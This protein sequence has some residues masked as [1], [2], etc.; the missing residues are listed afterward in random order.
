M[1][2]KQPILLKLT[3]QEIKT[4]LTQPSFILL[5][6]LAALMG[7]FVIQ[8][9]PITDGVNVWGPYYLAGTVVKL[10]FILP[11]LIAIF[12]TKAAVR[13]VQHNMQELIFSTAVSKFDWLASRWSGLFTATALV[14]LSFVLGMIAGLHLMELPAI[15]Y[16]TMLI[17]FAWPSLLFI[18]PAI[19]LAVSL[20]FAIGLFSRSSLVIF[21]FAGFAFIGYQTLLM[22]TGSPIMAKPMVL[23]DTLN[24]VFR[25]IDPVGSSVFFEQVKSWS[26]NARNSQQVILDTPLLLNRALVLVATALTIFF[27]YQKFSLTLALT[28]LKKTSPAVTNNAQPY[29]AVPINLTWSAKLAGFTSLCRL[30]YLTTIKTKSFALVSIFLTLVVA[31]EVFSGL[32]Y[33]ETMGVTPLPTT[34]VAFN[35]FAHDVLPNFG[36]LFLAF[37]VAQVMWRDSELNVACLIETTNTSNRQLFSAKWLTLLLIPITFISIAIIVASIMQ[38]L[39]G[40]TIEWAIYLSAFYYVGAPLIALA[41]LF[42][43]LHTLI[44]SK[45]VAMGLSFIV[46]VLAQSNFGSYIGIEHKML[47]FA[48]TPHMSH[49]QLI[50]FDATATAFNH[51]I[52]FWLAL[53]VAFALIGFGLFRRGLDVTLRQR[54]ILS[55]HR[56]KGHVFSGA[57]CLLAILG[58]GAHLFY[59]ANIIGQYKNSDAL[60]QWRVDYEKKYIAYQGLPQP[61]IVDVNT[62]LDFFPSERRFTLSAKYQLSNKTAKPISQVLIN[63]HH[64]LNYSSLTLS[65]AT[66]ASHDKALKQY[67]WQLNSPMQPGDTIALDFALD[68]QQTGHNGVIHDNF[69]SDKFSYFRDLRYMPFLGFAKH[70]QIKSAQTRKEHGLEPL[71]AA[72]SLEQDIALHQGDFSADYRWASTDITVSTIKGQTAIAPGELVKQWTVDNR[73]YFQYVNQQPMRRVLAYFSLDLVKSTKQVDGVNLE[74][75]HQSQSQD[76][77]NEHLAAMADTVTYANRHFSP[78]P[79]KQLRLIEVPS[80]LGYSGYALSQTILLDERFGFGVKRDNGKAIGFDHLYRRTV[81]ETAHQWWGYALDSAMTE[82]VSLLIESLAKLTEVLVLEKKF[83]PEYVRTLVRYEHNRYFSGRGNSRQQELP[84]YRSGE[85]HVVYSK[86]SVT[87]NALVTRLGEKALTDA[88]AALIKQHHYPQRPAT[89]LDFIARLKETSEPSQHQFIDHWLKN[90]AFDDWQITSAEVTE[91]KDGGFVA[92]VCY[93]NPSYV[94]NPNGKKSSKALNNPAQLVFLSAH[95]SRV[96]NKG[97]DRR[98]LKVLDIIGQPTQQ[99]AQQQLTQ[100]PSHIAI[101]PYYLTLDNSREDNVIAL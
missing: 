30:E 61:T 17:G 42:L 18:L 81:H 63:T 71:P 37:F 57:L 82:G 13:D 87:M 16:V 20:L 54:L 39:F 96:F 79:A 24:Q 2:K 94:L 69:I 29:Q 32:S 89:T 95:P 36:A 28:K 97:Q 21:I 83:G 80:V 66:L 31:S 33:L 59:Q 55:M 90:V 5:I 44:P 93:I 60:V 84:L 10:A 47:R 35:Q 43:L 25:L 65:G 64:L 34:S 4:Q 15:D 14:Y 74:V 101:D 23:S 1:S 85:S 6:V 62:Q 98:T 48:S 26:V 100:R 92:D 38:A 99:C 76:L 88:V 45:F 9:Q 86:A 91:N 27:T 3:Q 72:L 53:S 49:S 40:G 41:S 73:A 11:C 46:A 22:V 77:A 50:G 52:S 12:A 51:Y 67:L 68:Y 7:S 19:L 70:L 78:Y 8:H 75:Y 58:S 56:P